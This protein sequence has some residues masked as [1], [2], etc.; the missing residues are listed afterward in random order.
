MGDYPTYVLMLI[1]AAFFIGAWLVLR[2]R[3]K[4]ESPAQQQAMEESQRARWQVDK[5]R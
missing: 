4:R 3:W 2:I 5:K 1:L